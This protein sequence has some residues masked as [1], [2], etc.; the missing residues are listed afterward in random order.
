MVGSLVFQR[1]VA[2]RFGGLPR[3]ALQ[4]EA[5]KKSEGCLRS[6]GASGTGFLRA[7]EVCC[8]QLSDLPPRETESSVTAR[9]VSTRTDTLPHAK[10]FMQPPNPAFQRTAFGGR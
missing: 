4:A 5:L 9:W 2:A 6:L 1:F 10:T 3:S 8:W 7:A